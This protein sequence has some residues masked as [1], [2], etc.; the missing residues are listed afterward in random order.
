VNQPPLASFTAVADGADPR[1]FHFTST[2]TDPDTP[3]DQL[4]LAW[5]LNDDG[6]FNEAG[7]TKAT[8]TFPGPGTFFVSLRVSDGT[9]TITTRQPVT[10]GDRPPTVALSVS[11]N[12]A[13]PGQAVAV[14]A[15]ASD[16]DGDALTYAWDVNGQQFS[17]ATIP[18]QV[19]GA[20]GV[21]KVKVTVTAGGASA[22]D[23]DA[24]VVQQAP[25]SPAIGALPL[26]QPFPLVR[27]RGQIFKDGTKFDIV[28]AR[29]PRSARASARCIGKGCPR[30]W[31]RA[32]APRRTR[33]VRF[34]QLERKL[35]PGAVLEV[36][37]MKPGTIGKYARFVV[38]AGRPP[39]RRDRC[40]R[41]TSL[42]VVRCPTH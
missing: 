18:A 17:G 28:S 7:G 42:K 38:R 12:P 39:A 9:S 26:L 20:P 1:V 29:A 11:P 35:R 27:V 5:D 6:T 37:V 19:F 14:T 21:Y 34:T 41:G 25:S 24:I 31:M 40:V 15:K 16:P 30:R 13:L 8:A 2:S 3:A 4:Q 10:V 36:V 32:A 22:S 33:W 23:A